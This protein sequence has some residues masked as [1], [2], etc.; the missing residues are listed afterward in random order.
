MNHFFLATLHEKKKKKKD[1][2]HFGTEWLD[3]S[4][5]D[6]S[7]KDYISYNKVRDYDYRLFTL[8]NMTYA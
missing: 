7:N 5:E 2:K 3:P 8:Y 1:R 4:S 6:K